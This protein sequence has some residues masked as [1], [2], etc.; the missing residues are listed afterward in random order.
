MSDD[1][2]T[3]VQISDQKFAMLKKILERNKETESEKRERE[4]YRRIRRDEFIRNCKGPI[5]PELLKYC[6]TK[7]K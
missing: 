5:H 4:Y 1:K 3:A 2:L 6:I 7:D